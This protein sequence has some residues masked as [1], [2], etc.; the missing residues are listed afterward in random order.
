[1]N[2]PTSE[3]RNWQVYIVLC[4]DDSLYTG[5]TTNMQR[6]FRQHAEGSGAKYFRGRQPLKVVYLETD[7]NRASASKREA[8]V[9]ALTRS[10]KELLLSQNK[11]EAP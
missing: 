10:E 4:S 6:R 9:K 11:S 1:M 5:I 7:H 8:Q 2:D 3:D